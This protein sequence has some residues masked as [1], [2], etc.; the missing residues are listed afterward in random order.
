MSLKVLEHIANLGSTI[1]CRGEGG[2]GCGRPEEPEEG[3]AITA[4]SLRAIW[5]GSHFLPV[6]DGR[7]DRF[8]L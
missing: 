3:G 2:F 4:S 6:G 1:G 5:D 8:F 7:P